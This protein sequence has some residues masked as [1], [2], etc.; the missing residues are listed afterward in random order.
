MRNNLKKVKE[1]IKLI[2]K[3]HQLDVASMIIA[4]SANILEWDYSINTPISFETK[5]N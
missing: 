2:P 4:P 1:F 3:D 5:K